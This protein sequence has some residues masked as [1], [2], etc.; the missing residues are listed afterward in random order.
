MKRRALLILAAAILAV[1]MVPAIGVGAASGEVKIVTPDQLANPSGKGSAFDKLEAT[2]FVSDKTGMEETLEDAGGTLYVV[3]E[4]NDA[5]ANKLT[6]Y[7]AFFITIATT[8]EPGGNLFLIEPGSTAAGVQNGSSSTEVTDSN[9]KS[10]EDEDFDLNVGDRDRSGKIDADDFVFQIGMYTA[11][12]AA[13]DAESTPTPAEFTSERTLPSSSVFLSSRDTGDGF[14]GTVLNI[15]AIDTGDALR[16]TFASAGSDMLVDDKM[17][18]LVEVTSSSG[19]PIRIEAGE[20]DLSAYAEQDNGVNSMDFESMDA[21]SKDSG[22]FVGRFGVIRNDFK[23]A[24]AEYLKLVPKEMETKDRKVTVITQVLEEAE[25]ATPVPDATPTGVAGTPNPNTVGPADASGFTTMIEL[26]GVDKANTLVKGSLKVTFQPG[27]GDD[28]SARETDLADT[29]AI[30][31]VVPD[32]TTGAVTIT[33]TTDAVTEA[34][35]GDDDTADMFTL[36]YKTESPSGVID[37]MLEI[38]DATGT[39]DQGKT[40]IDKVFDDFCDGSGEDRDAKCAEAVKLVSA[41]E[42]HSKNL[43]IMMDMERVDAFLMAVIGVEHGDT[44]SVRYSDRSPRTVRIDSAEV[45]LMGPVI[46]GFSLADGAYIDD[47]DFEVLFNVTDADSGIL[48]DSDDISEA[49]IRKDQAYVRQELFVGVGVPATE[50]PIEDDSAELALDKDEISDGERY[51]LTIDVTDASKQAE[52][53]SQKAAETVRVKVT[54]TAYDVARNESMKTV[55][56]VV[57]TVDPVMKQAIT[58]WGVKSRT[59]SKNSVL[60]ENQRDRLA[61]VFDDTVQG[62]TVRPQ[63][64]RVPGSIVLRVTWLNNKGN[65]KLDV[66][67]TGQSETAMDL[68]YDDKTMTTDLATE[69]VAD[70][71]LARGKK[72]QDARHILFLTLDADLPTDAA[73]TVEIDRKDLVDLAGNENRSG[74]RAIAQDRLGPAFKVTVGQKLSNDG[75][76][77]MIEAS[78]SLDRRPRAMIKLGEDE[79]TARL[80]DLG[81]NMWEV[82]T[83]R[84]GLGISGSGAQD[85]VWTFTVSGADSEDNSGMGTAKWELDTQANNGDDPMRKGVAADAKKLMAQQL[86]VNEVT[87]LTVEFANEGDEYEAERG[88]DSSKTVSITGLMLET[89]DAGDINAKKMAKAA[90]D[91]TVAESMKIDAMSAQ[92]NDSVKHVVALEDL[93]QGNYN[94]K[95]EYADVAGNTG[96]FD[97]IFQVIAPRPAKI[98]VTPGWTLISIPGRPQNPAID[99]VFEGSSVTEVWSLN[100]ATKAWEFARK[101]DDGMWSESTLDQI[102]DGRGYFVRSSTFDPVNV[103]LQR[104]SPQREPPMY[105]ISAGWNSIGY[106]PA[107]SET[108]VEVDGYLS[109]LG[110]SGWGMIRTWSPD[111]SPPQYVTYYSSGAMTE[112]FPVGMEGSSAEGSAVVEAGKGYLLFATRSGS[113]GG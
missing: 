76:S 2:N 62:D 18:S 42:A 69:V 88:T 84:A 82:D 53:T 23:E 67:N 31:P 80:S 86:E 70:M 12:I 44:V 50:G 22:V 72:G 35:V 61:L 90:A 66:G 73:P 10:T 94:L 54:I 101:G 14:Y 25:N 51:E 109:A 77:V 81:K 46:G 58:G 15:P 65:N 5:T 43:G 104:F 41:V 20:K 34:K 78:E 16:V 68:D 4:D 74:H 37:A 106:T 98:E 30:G 17:K 3:I 33:V 47:D 95:V 79:I 29:G 97:Y 105:S 103:L 64:V 32:A 89:L 92:S 91:R 100:N 19:E 99:A 36:N 13:A 27:K 93:A 113:I 85:G 40:D 108:S 28:G 7:Y 75:L 1:A 8:G 59:G 57:D 102:V 24:I 112:G 107:G 6:D 21:K 60:V 49:K 45:D 56:Y 26:T 71:G 63:D 52:A 87:F 11:G 110:I 48:E 9:F 39:D 111:A 38:V 96:T 55:N 83:D